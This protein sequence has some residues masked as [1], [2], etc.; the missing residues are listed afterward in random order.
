MRRTLNVLLSV[1]LLVAVVTGCAAATPQVVRETVVVTSPP[2]VIRETVVVTAEPVVPEA[3][4]VVAEEPAAETSA[5][6]VFLFIGDGMGVAQRN[7]AEL[8][9][10]E[11]PAGLAAR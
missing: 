10:I 1:V 3:S 7:A 9:G 4:A 5:K 6:Y 2:E 8:Y 11:I